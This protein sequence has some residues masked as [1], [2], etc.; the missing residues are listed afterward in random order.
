[1][2][3]LEIKN[4]FD[5][6]ILADDYIGEKSSPIPCEKGLQQIHENKKKCIQLY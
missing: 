5:T 1:M 4:I 3:L 2:E 6:V